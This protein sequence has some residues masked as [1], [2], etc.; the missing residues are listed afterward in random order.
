MTG[1]AN[2]G[3]VGVALFVFLLSVYLLNFSGVAHSSDGIAM[4]ATSESIV[5]R[6]DLDMNA[7]LWM[8]LQQGSFGPDG[9]LYSR[10]GM[11]QTLAS[12]PLTWLGLK[13]P[14]LGVVQ[15]SLLLG[16][17]VAAATA[18]CLY[19]A[20]LA[21]G[22]AEGAALAVALLYGLAT[23]ALPYSKHDFSDPLTGLALVVAFLA[24]LRFRRDRGLGSAAL[25]GLVLGFATLTRTT[26]LVVVPLFVLAGAARPEG[27]RYD[28]EAGLGRLRDAA[29]VASA[30][31]ERTWASDGAGP[32]R[33]MHRQ[34]T[35]CR[36]LRDR[37]TRLQPAAAAEARVPGA[38]WR[39]AWPPLLAFSLGLGSL[40]LATG[41]SNYVR[42]GNPL[43]SGYLPQES[44]SGDLISGVAGLLVSPGKGLFLYAPVLLLAVAGW[45]R[46]RRTN[47]AAAWLLLGVF[48]AHVLVYGK[49]F[50]WHGGYA[51]GPR[52]LLPALPFVALAL[53]PLWPRW[54]WPA[55][56]LAAVSLVP[57]V[58]GS[59]V[60]F[61]PFQDSLLN[62]GLPLFAPVTFWQWRY[63][64]LLGQWRQ[65]A[66]ALRGAGAALDFGWAQDAFGAARV[67]VAVL[68]VLVTLVLLAAIALWQ[69]GRGHGHRLLPIAA[70]LLLPVAVFALARGHAAGTQPLD[71]ALR[72]I[73]AGERRG[74]ALLL[75]R[76]GD[77]MVL[78]D[79]YK[80]GLAVYGLPEAPDEW[81]A[82]VGAG[83]ER[84][85]LL[86]DDVPPE[87]SPVET[88]LAAWGYQMV[89]A[90][91]GGAGRLVLYA[92]P[93]RAL[94]VVAE[95]VAF[96][97]AVTLL[98]AEAPLTGGDVAV[99]LVWQTRVP[100]ARDLKVFVQ[101]FDAT[102][103]MLAQHDGA[104]DLWRRPT[105]TWQPGEAIEDR[106]GLL[107]P[108]GTR[109]AYLLIGLYDAA[110]G[111]RWPVAGGDA[112]R[113]DLPPG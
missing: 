97:D 72:L 46:L 29:E 9:Q 68:T 109:A 31:E 101:A 52:F 38:I 73:E 82:R 104:P 66:A 34:A 58:L 93:A 19:A 63:S 67:D 81:L 16:P 13:L 22:F 45:P 48:A 24:L 30:A 7:Y 105:T 12:L 98:S 95:D 80:G 42:F 76:P 75:T 71:A 23:P 8:G 83:Y 99:R 43:T 78:T 18:C 110:T 77:S 32:A 21:M 69:V 106:H 49:W 96:G 10:K 51:W 15:A 56:A 94:G 90:D 102:G 25:C 3:R 88:W 20:T 100:L 44:F 103:T 17:L 26:S 74:D 41:L 87:Q 53:A 60:H 84:L 40:L 111:E 55:L 50:M 61:A 47:A 54:R 14:W 4:L 89:V 28:D 92:R 11:G 65:V 62:T 35:A 5:R 86:T 57:Q 2:R 1:I 64:P 37:S 91:A 108:A 85:W 6:A 79:R 112:L 27:S 33:L 39:R 70:A 59:L 36:G 113:L 107:L